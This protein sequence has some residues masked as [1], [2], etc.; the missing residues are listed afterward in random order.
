MQ[1]PPGHPFVEY[2][3]QRL[4]TMV[5]ENDP[6]LHQMPLERI[7]GQ[8]ALEKYPNEHEQ[9]VDTEDLREIGRMQ[10][11]LTTA[12][13]WLNLDTLVGAVVRLALS[14]NTSAELDPLME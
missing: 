9:T 12:D 4:S 2:L 13:E 7:V 11:E 10:K 3:E 14:A 6:R 5:S 1:A 8:L